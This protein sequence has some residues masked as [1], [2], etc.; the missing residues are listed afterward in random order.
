MAATE[1]GCSPTTTTLLPWRHTALRGAPSA[2]PHECSRGSSVT[3]IEMSDLAANDLQL[4]SGVIPAAVNPIA[5]LAQFGVHGD[6]NGLTSQGPAPDAGVD[7]ALRIVG[8]LDRQLRPFQG[9]VEP[10]DQ[11]SDVTTDVHHHWAT[12]GWRLV[13]VSD[14]MPMG[15]LVCIGGG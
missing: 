8:K 9:I 6:H 7:V 13:H 1:C 14:A 12:L 15:V 5:A 4:R 11:P 2:A 3:K 10:H